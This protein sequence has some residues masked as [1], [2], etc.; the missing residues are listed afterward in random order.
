MCNTSRYVL[1]KVKYY[2]MHWLFI[3]NHWKLYL[4]LFFFF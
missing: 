3:E 2:G 4:N 1:V